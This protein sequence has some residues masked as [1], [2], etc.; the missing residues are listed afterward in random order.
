MDK[1]SFRGREVSA[2]SMYVLGSEKS[3]EKKE[4]FWGKFDECLGSFI[5]NVRVKV[6][7]DMLVRVGNESVVDVTGK[8]NA[9]QT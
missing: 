3:D 2:V 1:G 9:K 5:E 4:L 6:L 8:Y 7:S